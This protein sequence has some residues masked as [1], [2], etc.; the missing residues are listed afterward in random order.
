MPA[1][2]SGGSSGAAAGIKAGRAYVELGTED[3]SLKSGLDAAKGHVKAFGK[4]VAGIG[5]AIGGIG[6]A[7]EAPLALAMNSAVE[8]VTAVRKAA[9]QVGSSTEQFSALG[10]AAK[11]VG[12]D[13]DGLVATTRKLDRMTDEARSG[14]KAAAEEFEKLGLSADELAKMPLEEKYVAIADALAALPDHTAKSNAAFKLLGRTGVALLPILEKGGS[15]LREMFKEAEESGQIVKTADA[16]RVKAFTKT[17]SMMKETIRGLFLEIGLAV[18]PDVGKFKAYSDAALQIIRQT[19]EWVSQ[20]RGLVA[21]LSVAATGAIV[22]GAAIVTLGGITAATTSIVSAFVA[23]LNLVAAPELLIVGAFIAAGAAGAVLGYQISKLIDKQHTLERWA[24]LANLFGEA[25]SEGA[26][27]FT[28]AWEGISIALKNGDLKGAFSILITSLKLAWAELMRFFEDQWLGFKQRLKEKIKDSGLPGA[29]RIADQ[30]NTSKDSYIAADDAVRKTQ[31]DLDD[32]IK[33]Q[34][35]SL[36]LAIAQK[37]TFQALAM[38]TGQDRSKRAQDAAAI[39][40]GLDYVS[41]RQ[42]FGSHRASDLGVGAGVRKSDETKE[43][44]KANKKLEDIDSHIGAAAL[45][46]E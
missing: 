45:A 22:L 19:R 2:G 28:Q 8:H 42:Q 13:F 1:S 10:F 43:L 39:S 44:E 18:V 40:A 34:R 15:S 25:W 26:R 12:V 38:I 46:F 33:K 31:N 30:I 27:I 24:D 23:V 3:S 5:G 35:E 37:L 11:K 21:G 17:L 9:M 4:Q 7:I 32:L 29:S 14:N 41:T 20:N 36:L 16:E 6:A